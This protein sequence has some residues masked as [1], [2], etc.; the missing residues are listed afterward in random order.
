M[1]LK[2]LHGKGR[3]WT[4]GVHEKGTKKI[5]ECE[6]EEETGGWRNL[7]NGEHHGVY[8]SQNAIFT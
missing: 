5:L 6:R 4:G 8:S 1:D 3:T 2:V 7:C